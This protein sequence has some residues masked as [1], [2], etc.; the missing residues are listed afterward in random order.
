MKKQKIL[1]FRETD[2]DLSELL[3][4]FAVKQI[5]NTLFQLQ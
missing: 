3:R 1:T 2:V 4:V 5:I